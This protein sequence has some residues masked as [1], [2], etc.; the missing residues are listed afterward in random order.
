[1]HCDTLTELYALKCDVESA[2]LHISLEKAKELSPYIQIAAVWT[3]KRL[4]DDEA[5]DRFF[6]VIN[7]FRESPACK[8]GKIRECR[9]VSEFCSAVNDGV[10]AFVLSIEGA[11]LLGGDMT[12]FDSL[13]NEGIRLITLQWSGND[14]IGGAWDT[15]MPLTDFGRELLRRMAASGICADISHASDA[16]FDEVLDL[17]EDIRLTVCASHSNSRTVCNHRRNLTDEMFIRVMR[18][19]GIV[20]LSMAPEHLNTSGRADV[21]DICRHLYRYLELGGEDTVCFGCDFDGISSTPD[22]VC[23]IK[24]IPALRDAL[25]KEGFTDTVLDK[26]FYGN[27]HRFITGILDER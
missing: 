10:P 3:D 7:D 17:S 18:V 23:G 1:M 22:G 25:S 11:R 16:V 6:H 20:G 4:T 9:S 26:L 13:V 19:G 5:Y 15:D 8:G 2:P 12:R 14:C 24:D 21:S 27:A